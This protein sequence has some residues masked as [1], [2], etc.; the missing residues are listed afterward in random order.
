M[1]PDVAKKLPVLG[2][3]RRGSL[4]QFLHEIADAD[5]AASAFAASVYQKTSGRWAGV[6]GCRSRQFY[7][8]YQDDGVGHGVCVTAFDSAELWQLIIE[9]QAE[10]Q[11]PAWI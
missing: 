3:P 7:A 1:S 5:A 11:L 10:L 6:W 8:F 2:V 9:K 4:E